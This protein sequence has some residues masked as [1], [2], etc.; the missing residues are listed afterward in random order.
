MIGLGV[1]AASQQYECAPKPLTLP[2]AVLWSHEVPFKPFVFSDHARY[3]VTAMPSRQ[4]V[5]GV[6]LG[7]QKG[8]RYHLCQQKMRHA[9]KFA[10]PA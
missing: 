7:V 5:G 8:V 3:Y 9:L 1:K 4:A 6:C 2:K 10:L